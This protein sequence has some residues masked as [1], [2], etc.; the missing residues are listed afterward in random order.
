MHSSCR[1]H[2][3]RHWLIAV[4]VHLC[5]TNPQKQVFQGFRLYIFCHDQTSLAMHLL[6]Y[7]H[8][9]D[10]YLV[11]FAIMFNSQF[12]LLNNPLLPSQTKQSEQKLAFLFFLAT[13]IPSSELPFII[14]FSSFFFLHFFFMVW[15]LFGMYLLP[16]QQG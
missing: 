7:N 1:F 15:V 16:S 9:H 2:I 5:S 6:F 3:L 11:Q 12:T 14:S 8:L 13:N 4:A 10:C